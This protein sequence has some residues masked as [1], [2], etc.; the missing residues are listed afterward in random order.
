V[1]D[2]EEYLEED[3]GQGKRSADQIK[4]VDKLAET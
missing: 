3:E 4:M 1:N 2:K